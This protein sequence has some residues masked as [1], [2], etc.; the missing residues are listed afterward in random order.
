MLHLL[1]ALI[2][3]LAS[4]LLTL[5]SGLQAQAESRPG[6]ETAPGAE[7]APGANGG[8][9]SSPHVG[10]ALGPSTAEQRALSAHLRRRGALFYGAWWCPA[11]FKQ[12]N[13]F[14]REA[15]NALPYVE[16]DK[17]DAGRQRCQAAGIRA[18][19]TWELEGRRLEGVRSLQELKQWSGFPEEPNPAEPNP[20]QRP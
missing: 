16:C 10:E 20:A 4:A 3:A 9:S 2:P 17:T 6:V 11:C 14:G 5:A 19:P 13:L 18:Y 1:S 8:P 15:G 12:K 7:A